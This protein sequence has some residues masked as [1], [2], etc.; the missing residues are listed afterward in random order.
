MCIIVHVYIY[1][2]QV[3]ASQWAIGTTWLMAL[4]FCSSVLLCVLLELVSRHMG[5]YML[6]TLCNTMYCCGNEQSVQSC[7]VLQCATNL[8]D[9]SH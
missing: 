1:S 4:V 6:F 7:Y 5:T 2:M 8:K 9:M 3:G